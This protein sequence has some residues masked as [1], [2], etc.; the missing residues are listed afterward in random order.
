MSLFEKFISQSFCLC[1]NNFAKSSKA[2]IKNLNFHI[3]VVILVIVSASSQ[4]LAK[5][6]CFA[7]FIY[8]YYGE[9]ELARNLLHN[10]VKE[11]QL[12]GELLVLFK[13][14]LSA[15]F[16]EVVARPLP[17]TSHILL[18]LSSQ[19][20]A[21][22]TSESRKRKRNEGSDVIPTKLSSEQLRA[23]PSENKSVVSDSNT[24]ANLEKRVDNVGKSLTKRSRDSSGCASQA[25]KTTAL[26]YDWSSN[27]P[28]TTTQ[29]SSNSLRDLQSLK[30]NEFVD[31]I[32]VVSGY[33]VIAKR[34][35]LD[36]DV[37]QRYIFSGS[38]LK[39]FNEAF[40]IALSRASKFMNKVKEKTSE[41]L[42]PKHM[43][44]DIEEWCTVGQCECQQ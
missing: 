29:I 14:L 43:E 7:K 38:S 34:F 1:G 8:L 16:G 4:G 44:E 5:E 33:D 25:A 41:S 39:G 18:S 27:V 40:K 26:S 21:S 3:F 11:K 6:A 32:D 22:S 10:F 31:S 28:E 37:N 24:K 23:Q 9:R 12:S 2:S 13:P 35:K 19:S 30:M 17:L 42:V 20:S 15:R 36:V